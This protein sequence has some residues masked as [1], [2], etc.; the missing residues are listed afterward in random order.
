MS[1]ELVTG[2]LGTLVLGLIGLWSKA[3]I[4]KRANALGLSEQS[5]LDF[6]AILAPLQAE[7]GDLRTRVTTLESDIRAERDLRERVV[8][9]AR[10]LYWSWK[11]QFPDH[12]PPNVPDSIGDYFN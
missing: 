9:Y 1:W 2:S 8:S 12:P 10:S 6:E 11:R 4:D 5:R 7:V 3:K